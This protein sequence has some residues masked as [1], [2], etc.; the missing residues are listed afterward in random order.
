MGITLSFF[1]LAVLVLWFIIGAKGSWVLKMF[2]ISGSLYL[3][4]SV[5]NSLDGF[6]GWAAASDMPPKFQ[7]HWVIIDEP[8]PIMNHD[9]IIYIWA[10]GALN[11]N[12]DNKGWRDWLLLFYENNDGKPRAYRIPYSIEMHER[13]EP[14][15]EKMKMGERIMGAN[16]GKLK[17]KDIRKS[18]VN[19]EQDLFFYDFP[20]VKMQEK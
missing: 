10:T 16:I 15:L 18:N 5:S 11:K 17:K 6:K 7:V 12:E 3:F 19:E 2:A 13:L 8:N 1:I 4:L 9:G 14:I 20:K